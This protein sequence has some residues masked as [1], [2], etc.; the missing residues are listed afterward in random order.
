[1]PLA[2]HAKSRFAFT[3]ETYLVPIAIVLPAEDSEIT[4][5]IGTTCPLWLDV[6][7]L[8][9]VSGFALSFGDGISELAALVAIQNHLR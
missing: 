3:I 1:L 9:E 8:Q 5:V 2:L 7:D 4:E 6:I